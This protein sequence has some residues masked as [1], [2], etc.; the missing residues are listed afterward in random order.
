MTAGTQPLT[1]EQAYAQLVAALQDM[2]QREAKARAATDVLN[3]MLQ[4][5]KEAA[6]LAAVYDIR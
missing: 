3:G 4:S 2:A 5:R 1:V 6:E